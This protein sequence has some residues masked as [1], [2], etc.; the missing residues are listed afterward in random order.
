MQGEGVGKN[1][2]PLPISG[3]IACCQRRDRQVVNRFRQQPS[4]CLQLQSYSNL[5]PAS[6]KRHGFSQFC[7]RAMPDH[8]KL[9]TLIACKRRRL[10]F[11]GDG[12]RS[13]YDKKPQ[14]YTEQNRTEY[15]C[16]RW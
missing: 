10:L 5:G 16:T 9:V 12:R 6:R 7:S 13:L 15:N 8:C 3:F 4:G 2:D 14:R 11:A 1:C